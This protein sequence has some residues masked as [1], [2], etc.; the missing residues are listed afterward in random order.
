[1]PGADSWLEWRGPG[2]RLCIH[3]PGVLPPAGAASS[4]GV[5]VVSHGYPGD[6]GSPGVIPS[7]LIALSG[8]LA[9][10]SG[11]RVVACCLR[12]VGGSEGD[13]SLAGWLDDLAAVVSR[14]AVEA[15]GG[16]VWLVGL[17]TSGS[18]ALCLA[19]DDANVRGIACLAAHANFDKW[20]ADPAAFA[21]QALEIGL[22][23]TPG[24]VSDLGRWAAGLSSIRPDVD[25]AR[26]RA[27]PVLI[28]HGSD[29]EAV[30]VADARTL[31]EAVGELAELRVL[32]GA[33]HTLNSDPRAIAL[34]LGWLERRPTG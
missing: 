9:S 28:L 16:G 19:A 26:L 6:K 11:M 13:F 12:G 27:R 33:G 1:M 5:V 7:S 20:A 15:D 17:G 3:E 31:A 23:K 32:A 30:P 4:G 2:G 18:L 24:A 21:G 10:D 29:D 34:L 14:A 22:V 8:R 25:A